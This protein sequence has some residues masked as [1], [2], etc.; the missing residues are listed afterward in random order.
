[1]DAALSIGDAQPISPRNRAPAI[2]LNHKRAALFT[3]S[4]PL[5]SIHKYSSY[6]DNLS[7]FGIPLLPIFF[8]NP[9]RIESR[10][11][12]WIARDAYFRASKMCIGIFLTSR[13]KSL[14]P[15]INRSE[16]RFCTNAYDSRERWSPSR[17]RGG[18][19]KITSRCGSINDDFQ[20]LLNARHPALTPELSRRHSLATLPPLPSPPVFPIPLAEKVIAMR[21][22]RRS[23]ETRH[24][25]SVA[26]GYG[27]E[28]MRARVIAVVAEN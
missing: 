26:D 6:L 11:L 9:S 23:S 3:S 18:E 12:S 7:I 13:R 28:T 5:A 21:I 20:S 27:I 17:R 22:T 10:I 1:M 16:I 2:A 4:F 8:T 15:E 19:A 25:S 14:F 24:R